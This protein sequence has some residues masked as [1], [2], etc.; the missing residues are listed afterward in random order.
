MAETT[1]SKLMISK[2]WPLAKMI[3]RADYTASIIKLTMTGSIS[4]WAH[5]KS[6]AKQNF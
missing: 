1:M 2:N 3:S 5:L 4:L 6:N